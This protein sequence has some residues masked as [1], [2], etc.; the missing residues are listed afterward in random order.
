MKR[1]IYSI[2]AVLLVHTGY[3]QIGVGTASPNSNLD[4]RGAMAVS[5]RSFAGNTSIGT[6]DYALVYTGTTAGTATLPNAST[7]NGRVYWIKNASTTLPVPVLTIAT[8]S[9][10]TID[11]AA[12][13]LLDEPNETVR[14]MSNGANWNVGVQDVPVVKSTTSGSAWLQGG[15]KLAAFKTAG[16]ISTADFS[17]L[18]NN[19]EAM[20]ISAAG[21][22]GIGTSNPAGG[23][24]F[25]NDN[26]TNSDGY[27]MD[28]YMNG[29]NTITAGI[30]LRKSRGTVAA[31]LDLQNGDIISQFRFS[32]H[33]N[34]SIAK[35]N[36]SGIDA[37]YLGNGNTDTTDLRWFASGAECMRINQSGNLGIG[38]SVFSAGNPEVV[39]VD[40]GVTNS[41]NV[42]SGKGD[43]NNYLQ[44]NIQNKSSGSNASSDIVATADNG[45]ENG[46]YIDMGINSGG[47]SNT[48]LPILGTAD[49]GYLYSTAGDF[50]IG[51]GTAGQDLIF[52]ND[53]IATSDEALRITATGNTGIGVSNP[54]DKLSVAGI[55]SPSSDNTYTLGTSTNRWS[56]IWATN[57]VIQ[58]S[59]ARLKT[60]I[61]PLEYGTIQLMQLKPVSYHWK[62]DPNGRRQVGMIAQET[63]RVIPE[64]VTG[65]E[66]KGYLGMNYAELVPVLINTLHEQQ[67]RLAKL[68]KE[69]SSL[70]KDNK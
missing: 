14:L 63:R 65:N 8:A 55:L 61:D 66:K 31:A 37:Y 40:A 57:G 9:S 5:L 17:F 23:L 19:I 16:S 4:I 64:V 11:G 29:V 56:A 69:L 7:C 49:K 27:Y 22:V 1:I 51:N 50:V 36:S 13:W 54:G 24:H 28:D 58:T 26:N 67:Q 15:N 60:N 30:Y 10:Q 12:S 2:I 48:S 41:Y 62:T 25:V 42:I 59:D 45:N 47:Y 32:P 3:A 44:L 20:H 43:I 35:A 21:N 18:T 33:Y 6:T 46:N 53:G 34:G 70:E 39:M 38:S 68:E 52:F